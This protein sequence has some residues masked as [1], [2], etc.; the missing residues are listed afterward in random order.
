[1]FSRLYWNQ[2]V[3]PF[4]Q[5][6]LIHNPLNEIKFSISVNLLH[7]FFLGK[8]I[9]PHWTVWIKKSDACNVQSDLDLHRLVRKR[10]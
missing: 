3:R 4:I 7:K 6:G 1:M 5:N 9:C 10:S 2:P 8:K